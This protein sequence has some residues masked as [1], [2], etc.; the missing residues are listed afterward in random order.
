MGSSR[1]ALGPMA[2]CDVSPPEHPNHAEARPLCRQSAFTKRPRGVR[3][4][5]LMLRQQRPRDQL[6]LVLAQRG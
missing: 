6:G 2:A 3:L 5:D 1:W 4:R